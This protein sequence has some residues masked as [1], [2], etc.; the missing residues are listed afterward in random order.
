MS[1]WFIVIPLINKVYY[2][3]EVSIIN[4]TIMSFFWWL[5]LCVTD[6][7]QEWPFRVPWVYFMCGMDDPLSYS[8]TEQYVVLSAFLSFRMYEE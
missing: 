8:H 7:L 3:E 5:W 1:P 6:G 4:Y 2:S